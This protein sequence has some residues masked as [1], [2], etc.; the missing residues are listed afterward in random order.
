MLA[1]DLM[2]RPHVHKVD[3]QFIVSTFPIFQAGRAVI[4]HYS[5]FIGHFL[6]L[7]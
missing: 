5:L 3:S 1:G 6:L 4:I 7:K 2:L